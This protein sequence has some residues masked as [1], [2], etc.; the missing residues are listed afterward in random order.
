MKDKQAHENISKGH[1]I[2]AGKVN[3]ESQFQSY[4][5]DLEKW[6]EKYNDLELCFNKMTEDKDRI[7]RELQMDNMDLK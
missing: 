5:Y 6:K 4:A 2:P 7:I 1:R 3:N